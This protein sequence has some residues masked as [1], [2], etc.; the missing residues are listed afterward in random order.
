MKFVKIFSLSMLTLFAAFQM[1]SAKTAATS[2][3][4]TVVRKAKP[5]K[6]TTAPA[7][8]NVLKPVT[9]TAKRT[10][11]KKAKT[12]HAGASQKAAKTSNKPSTEQ[13]HPV[14]T[15]PKGHVMHQGL[16]PKDASK[17]KPKPEIH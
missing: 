15:D 2:S 3:L 13:K 12:K 9:I 10:K 11:V 16:A 7:N 6:V 14:L 8:A 5:M 17:A 4:A 1:A